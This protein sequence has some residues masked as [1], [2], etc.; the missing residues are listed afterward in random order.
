MLGWSGKFPDNPKCPKFGISIVSTAYGA[1][2]DHADAQNLAKPPFMRICRKFE[3]WR[4]L[5][6]LSGHFLW[7]K[8][9]YPESFHFLWLWLT[10][11]LTDTMNT[12]KISSCSCIHSAQL[13]ILTC[14]RLH[15]R[16]L[17]F[18]LQ[19]K[20]SS[21]VCKFSCPCQFHAFLPPAPSKPQLVASQSSRVS[22]I[23]VPGCHSPCLHYSTSSK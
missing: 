3:N 7:Q 20:S 1:H 10:L 5:R 22:Y 15:P 16:T 11:T 8:S 17:L 19:N 6:A 9:C 12:P 14:P 18:I 21:C 2:L 13:D 4:D 23:L